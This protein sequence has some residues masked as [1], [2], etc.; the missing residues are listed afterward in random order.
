MSHIFLEKS[1]ALQLKPDR[2]LNYLQKP[3]DHRHRQIFWTGYIVFFFFLL[4]K[5]Q[6]YSTNY[7]FTHIVA[8]TVNQ[9]NFAAIKFCGL[10]I[11]A[12]LGIF[13]AIKFRVLVFQDPFLTKIFLHKSA[14]N[15]LNYGPIFKI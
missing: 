10:L 8:N 9:L 1:L 3:P 15:F 5:G 12:N 13:H 7:I 2:Q 11:I 6:T 14:C 4:T